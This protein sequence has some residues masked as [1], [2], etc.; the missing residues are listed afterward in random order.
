MSTEARTR[1]SSGELTTGE[2]YIVVS[3]DAHASPAD[4][5]LY[6]SYVDPADRDAIAEV[7]ELSS[8]A[9][10]MFGGVDQGEIEDPDPVR[11][12]AAA[13]SGSTRCSSSRVGRCGS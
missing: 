9:L 3:A 7:G 5:D 6:L 4:F 1:R 12:T 2:P 8:A 11:A 10:S 13:S